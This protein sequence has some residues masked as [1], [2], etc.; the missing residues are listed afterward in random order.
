MKGVVDAPVG[1]TGGHTENPT[2]KQVCAGGTG[3]AEAVEVT[4]D[5]G[6]ISY[7]K[8]LEAFFAMHDAGR[9]GGQYG[10]A[11]FFHTAGQKEQAEAV[12]ARLKKQGRRIAT[13]LVPAST[14]WRAEEYHQRYYEKARRGR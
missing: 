11:I 6:L 7:E 2:Y 1:Y 5:P 10:S 8:L 9:G 14:F 4:F 13:A 3:H 12:I